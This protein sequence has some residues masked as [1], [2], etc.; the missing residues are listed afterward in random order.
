MIRARLRPTELQPETSIHAYQNLIRQ[1]RAELA[2]TRLRSRKR[3][4][5]HA[6]FMKKRGYAQGY[7]AGVDEAKADCAR[8][9]EALRDAYSTA[10][11]AAQKDI[12]ATAQA[13]AER[14]IDRSLLENPEIMSS[15]IQQSIEVLKRSRPLT[16]HYHPR[17]ERIMATVAPTLPTEVSA[18]A[19]SKLDGIDFTIAG[20][21]G[22]VE[23]S[24]RESLRGGGHNE[25]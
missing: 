8:A 5:S 17:Y 24:W 10:L 1:G 25:R 2:N 16:L 4:V 7:Q 18:R 22:G 3:A 19:D 21:P 9:I 11:E 15:W 20:E 6:R 13:M 14:F 23:F 12:L